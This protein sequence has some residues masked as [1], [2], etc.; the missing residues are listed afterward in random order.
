S[1]PKLIEEYRAATGLANLGEQFQTEVTQA[2]FQS[3]LLHWDIPKRVRRSAVRAQMNRV[4]R[5][6]S[7]LAKQLRNFQAA[8]DDLIPLY[9]S[10]VVECLD[11]KVE[12]CGDL[13]LKLER[14]P[15]FLA[16]KFEHVSNLAAVSARAFRDEGGA[17]SMVEFRELMR[18]LANAFE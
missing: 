8:L 2:V 15:S 4:A 9:R 18:S 1:V 17:P 11:L 14:T 13:K 12:K 10:N 7:T 16:Q 3:V 5:K 6:A